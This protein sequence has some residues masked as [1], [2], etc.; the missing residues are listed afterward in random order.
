MKRNH[1]DPARSPPRLP[2]AT[3]RK[4]VA[5]VPGPPTTG[6]PP[7]AF[8]TIGT[9]SYPL[10]AQSVGARGLRGR[11]QRLGDPALVHRGACGRDDPDPRPDGGGRRGAGGRGRA[12]PDERSG[13][14]HAPRLQPSAGS[15]HRE[16]GGGGTRRPPGPRLLPIFGGRLAVTSSVRSTV[17]RVPDAPSGTEQLQRPAPKQ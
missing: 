11:R 1:H 17:T 10:R 2:R 12:G 3:P 9:G 14:P 13:L 4:A 16:L 7:R 5:V 15:V 8:T 6:A